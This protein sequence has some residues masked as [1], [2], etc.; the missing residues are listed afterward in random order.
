MFRD[1]QNILFRSR[2]VS[3]SSG[4]E[5]IMSVL[6]WLLW[7]EHEEDLL[8]FRLKHVSSPIFRLK[9]LMWPQQGD[10]LQEDVKSVGNVPEVER[11]SSRAVNTVPRVEVRAALAY[12]DGN[13]C[14][15]V[16]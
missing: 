8:L 10:G 7:R 11:C 2:D 12:R 6:V 5:A 15:G 4:S 3:V 13:M 14:F 16:N 1:G 9:R